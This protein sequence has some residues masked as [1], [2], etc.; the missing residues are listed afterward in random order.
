MEVKVPY[1]IFVTND[2]TMFSTNGKTETKYWTFKITST[3]DSDD[4]WAVPTDVDTQWEQFKQGIINHY[5]SQGY[6]SNGSGPDTLGIINQKWTSSD[7]RA[8]TKNQGILPEDMYIP[9]TTMQLSF[10]AKGLNLISQSEKNQADYKDDDRYVAG[11]VTTA[12]LVPGTNIHYKKDIS[13]NDLEHDYTRKIILHYW[14]GSTKEIDQVAPYTQSIDYNVVTGEEERYGFYGDGFPEYKLPAY[15]FKMHEPN[16]IYSV[17]IYNGVKTTVPAD[18]TQKNERVDYYVG[19]PAHYTFKYVNTLTGEPLLADGNEENSSYFDASWAGHQLGDYLQGG[20]VNP[21][22]SVSTNDIQV[23][24]I[25]GYK[26][27]NYDQVAKMP[28]K[29]QD[30]TVTL[31]YAPLSPVV[32]NYVDEDSGDVIYTNTINNDENGAL[33]GQHYTTDQIDIP[34][35]QFDHVSSNANGV[36]GQYQKQD[37]ENPITV[38]Y[39]YKVIPGQ[40]KIAQYSRDGKRVDAPGKHFMG[41][42]KENA[43]HQHY[44]YTQINAEF[45]DFLKQNGYTALGGENNVDGIM[46]AFSNAI[47]Y[48]YKK[49]QPITV[50][51]IK[52]KV[53]SKGNVVDTGDIIKTEKI[54]YTADSNN[55]WTANAENIPGYVFSHV[56]LGEMSAN[57]TPYYG[58]MDLDADATNSNSTSGKFT[59][60]PQQ[61]N[62]YYFETATPQTEEKTITRVIHYVENSTDGRVLKDPVT[63]QVTLTGTYYVSDGKRVNVTPLKQNGKTIY[64]VSES[65]TPTETWAIKANPQSHDVAFNSSNNQQLDFKVTE[66]EEQASLD[67]PDGQESHTWYYASTQNKDKQK[68][69]INQTIDLSKLTFDK[70]GNATLDPVYRIYTQKEFNADITYYDDTAHT[71]LVPMASDI[72]NHGYQGDTIHFAT[73]P[74]DEIKSLEDKG[75]V[76]VSSNYTE[77]QKYGTDD[78]HFAVHLVHG[79]TQQTETRTATRNVHY[80]EDDQGNPVDATA[81]QN[82][83]AQEVTFTGTYYTD[84]VTKDKS[85]KVNTKTIN[86]KIVVKDNNGKETWTTKA[87]Q[88][89]TLSTDK[90]SAS[91]DQVDNPATL[92]DNSNHTWILTAGSKDNAP[93]EK[94]VL[95]DGKSSTENVYLIYTQKEFNAD[96]TYY[97]DTTHTVLVP[98]ASDTDHHG[99]QGDTIHFA[100]DPADEI[101]SLENKGYVLVSNNYAEGQKY[102][103]DDSHFAVHLVHGANQQTETKTATRNVHYVE[104]DPEKTALQEPTAQEVTFTGTYYTDAVTKDKSVKVNTKTINGKLVVKDNNGKETWTTKATQ[105]STMNADQKNAS[106]DKVDGPKTLKDR[107]NKYWKLTDA[108]S[109]NAPLK[110]AVRPSGK[111]STSDVYLIYTRDYIYHEGKQ[112]TMTFTRTIKYV[113]DVT[114]DL[115]PTELGPNGK[116]VITQTTTISRTPIYNDDN[117]F[118]G[119]GTVDKN[120]HFVK[121]DG[122]GWSTS[123]LAKQDSP[124]LTNAG[125][126]PATSTDVSDPMHVEKET[127]NENSPKSTTITIKYGHQKVSVTPNKASDQN[128]TPNTL[129]NQNDPRT[130]DQ[131]AK[132]G[133]QADHDTLTKKVSRTITYQ[134]LNSHAAVPG[135]PEGKSAK[136]QTAT[137]YITAV[138]DKVTGQCLGYNTDGSNNTPYKTADEAWQHAPSQTFDEVDSKSPATVGYDHVDKAKVSGENVTATSQPANVVVN[139]WNNKTTTEVKTVKE[140]IHYVY[141]DGSKAQDDYVAKPLTFTHTVVKDGATGATISDTWTQ[142]QT[143]AKVVSPTIEGYT[144]D[145][146]QIDPKT[147]NHNSSDIDLTVIYKANPTPK[148]YKTTV[149]YVDQNGHDL[150]PSVDGQKGLKTGDSFDNSNKKQDT[151]TVKGTQYKLV[152]STNVTGKI[153]DSDETTTYVYEKV[154]TPTPKTY[155]TTV[156]YVDQNGHDLI[157]SV[158]GQKGLK[159]GDSF[160]NSNKK[161]DTIIVKGTQYKLV[162]STNV[163]GKINDHDAT[164]TYIYEKVTTPTPKTYK[165]TVKYIDQNGHDLIPSVDGQKGLKTGDSFDNSNKKQDTITVDGTQYKLV[166]STNVTGKISDQDETTTYVYEKVT[167]PTPKTYKTTVKYVDQNG[168]DLIPS[169]DGQKG[170]KTGDSFD[171]S[172]KKQDTI[173]VNGTQYKLVKSTNVTGKINDHDATTTYVYEKVTTPTPTPDTYKVTVNYQDEDGHMIKDAVVVGDKYTNGDHYDTTNLKSATIEF[174]GQTYDFAQVLTGSG[175]ETGT[176]NGYDVVITYVYKLHTTPT[177]PNTPDNPGTPDQPTNPTNPNQPTTPEQPSTPVT[178]ATPTQPTTPV[179]PTKPGKS[180]VSQPTQPVTVQETK[181]QT[182]AQLPQTG[183]DNRGGLI[184]LGLTGLFAALGLGKRKRE[185]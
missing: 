122:D 171:N 114:G 168:H 79:A 15:S 177:T 23:M 33:P 98:M 26:L 123:S 109:N 11:P 2:D 84:A 61:V 16:K 92:Q 89:S 100:T 60:L 30:T 105:N 83:T 18:S 67:D 184:A 93:E 142:D 22:G 134:D 145:Q 85:V 127:I 183:N 125:Y 75:Y 133:S 144:P 167:T 10:Y 19:K 7:V 77:G 27:L 47:N 147:V 164:T 95:P 52:A 53:D 90:Q 63:Q 178:P 13:K 107:S 28:I 110:E 115:I 46:T 35:Y 42:P 120:G 17:A 12:D 163:T 106:F 151:I 130:P 37:N 174:N 38:T 181:K 152:K 68:T 126:T 69:D 62:F 25:G 140:T 87:T 8:I 104:D 153:S 176:I 64:V 146:A 101:K 20:D 113:D 162:K 112:E 88:N 111:S 157:P 58:T 70:D 160:D 50:N 54:D 59:L 34:G 108:S 180:T 5:T 51:Y 48:Y 135:S 161:Q 6:V 36:V 137:F 102:G 179:Q 158:D 43:I 132:Y 128:K 182:T 138:F 55:A 173:T 29:G 170:L 166:K 80:V 94:A 119:Y 131:Q 9:D 39:Y 118:V 45:Q 124:D 129:I 91:F 154:T 155:K 81:L 73:D 136:T 3:G 121:S 21:D 49:D 72:D 141:S 31:E 139:Y 32:T 4:D 96:I 185:D 175:S 116:N 66:N 86:G 71:V 149:K 40:E 97:D 159:T 148:T 103:T 24:Q 99:H 169:V 57:N 74:A 65:T 44:D 117:K 156:K 82:P 150:I 1:Q 172:A 165:T 56:E 41:S 78:S 143:F 14:D 76:L